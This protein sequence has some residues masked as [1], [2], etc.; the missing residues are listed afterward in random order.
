VSEDRNV[1][2]E[3]SDDAAERF[4]ERFAGDDDDDFEG[5]RLGEAGRLSTPE[6]EEAERV[7]DLDKDRLL[8]I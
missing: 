6:P 7:V 4:P 1:E 5:H 3:E 2:N 8:D